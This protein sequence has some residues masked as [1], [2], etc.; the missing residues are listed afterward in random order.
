MKDYINN[1][2]QDQANGYILSIGDILDLFENDV[3][4]SIDIHCLCHG[5]RIEYIPS[6]CFSWINKKFLFFKRIRYIKDNLN[7]INQKI[8]NLQNSDDY[9]KLQDDKVSLII[10][11]YDK[12]KKQYYNYLFECC[13]IVRDGSLNIRNLT[14]EDLLLDLHKIKESLSRNPQFK[15]NDL[16]NFI[17]STQ[18]IKCYSFSILPDSKSNKINLNDKPF[19]L[20]LIDNEFNEYLQECKKSG[21][22]I[23]WNCTNLR[24]YY[25]Y[26][27][28]PVLRKSDK[29]IF[30]KDFLLVWNNKRIEIDQVNNI[31]EIVDTYATHKLLHDKLHPIINL[32]KNVIDNFRISYYRKKSSQLNR[33]RDFSSKCLRQILKTTYGHSATVRLYDPY[34]KSLTL[35]QE[36]NTDWGGRATCL[37]EQEYQKI[38]IR[39]YKSSLNAFTFLKNSKQSSFSY[40]P[41]FHKPIPNEYRELGLQQ[42]LIHRDSLS[43]ICFPLLCGQ[44]AFG[45]LNIESPIKNAFDEDIE[46]LL[47]IKHILES[48]YDVGLKANDSKWLA[49]RSPVYR[50]VHELSQLLRPE[51]RIFNQ[52]QID[53]LNRLIILDDSITERLNVNFSDLY[54]DIIYWLDTV[55]DH[56]TSKEIKNNFIFDV[57]NNFEIRSHIYEKVFLICKNIFNNILD[58][59]DPCRDKFII[60]QND[61][62]RMG[63]NAKIKMLI[64]TFGAFDE[65]VIDNLLISPVKK[66][67]QYH[68]GMFLVGMLSRMLEGTALISNGNTYSPYTIIEISLPLA[69]KKEK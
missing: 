48:F 39:H 28:I 53:L 24:D 44:V 51:S 1:I 2:K 69:D 18:K 35:F 67:N 25:Y 37:I 15:L 68:Y 62:L 38:K 55:S 31:I 43:E 47:G 9:L 26:C 46:Y 40:I 17:T 33:F 30:V 10:F 56:I 29:P 27:L 49:G 34:Y 11:N 66:D 50:N 59:G 52:K 63:V 19:L 8:N 58:H 42:I 6:L 57:K 65:Q 13:K 61:N 36:D 14:K 54:N 7:S 16:S 45:T 23:A 60:M 20:K 41:N 12:N 21:K 5:E 4:R 3:F 32:Q 64:K 22:P